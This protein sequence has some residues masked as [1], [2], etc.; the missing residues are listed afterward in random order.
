MN[1]IKKISNF[2]S[3]NL[4]FVSLAVTI[5]AVIRPNIFTWATT[6]LTLLQQTV[7]FT[8]GFTLLPEDFVRALKK[9][10]GII[11]VELMQFGWMPFAGWA[12][13]K[14]LSVPD[15]IAI[16]VILVGCCPGGTAS[17]IITYLSNGDVALSVSCTAISTVLSPLLTPLFFKVY[18]G[19]IVEV[20]L[21]SMLRS[22]AQI[23]LIPIVLGI[24][25]NAVLRKY[26]NK[27][28]PFLPIIS[29]IAFMCSLGGI[30][31]ANIGTLLTSGILIFFVCMLHNVSGLAFGHGLCRLFKMDTAIT[32]TVAVEIGMQNSGIA[33]NLAFAYYTPPSALAGAIFGIWHSLTGSIY[34]GIC[35]KID[36]KKGETAEI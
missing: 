8:M 18:A 30:V 23:V 21:L 34:A 14:I 6:R 29:T 32:R 1:T 9:P 16:G 20:S 12:L 22:I 28:T 17:N 10:L 3:Q 19:G 26:N 31:S 24:V 5:V 25:L 33:S 27:I 11:L 13:C 2:I 15:E 7:M 36:A 35:R 4:L